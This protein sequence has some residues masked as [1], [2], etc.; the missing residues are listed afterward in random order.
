SPVAASNVKLPV[1]L[2]IDKWSFDP[3]PLRADSQSLTMRV[4]I[5][6]TCG[7]SVSGAHVYSVAI[8]FNQ[9]SVENATTGGDGFAAIT[10]H[11]LSGYPANPGRQQILAVQIRTN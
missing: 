3:N 10:F 7:R 4:H 1:R 9:T 6:D 8:P 11:I 2:L 5:A